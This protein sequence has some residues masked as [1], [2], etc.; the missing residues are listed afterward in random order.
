MR[1]DVVL[2][3]DGLRRVTFD[4][5]DGSEVAQAYVFACAI[6]RPIPSGLWGTVSRREG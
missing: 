4:N 5:S 3:R 2:T 6:G 1:G